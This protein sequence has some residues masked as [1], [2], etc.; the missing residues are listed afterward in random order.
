M[1]VSLVLVPLAVAAVA[2]A[3]G[4]TAG[5]DSAGRIVCQVQTRM[6]DET[7]LA[8]ALRESN[9]VVT[10]D[11]KDIVAAWDRVRANFRRG[12]DGVWSAHL[13]GDIDEQRAVDIIRAVDAGYGRQVQRAVL[14]RLRE[15]A[16]AAGLRLESESVAEDA[17]V[18]LVFAVEGRSS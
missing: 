17:S 6:R 10:A 13:T 5:R 16:P 7:L 8:A 11:G 9:A 15:R 4:A 2:A 3:H 18:R 12:Q 14:E 1:S